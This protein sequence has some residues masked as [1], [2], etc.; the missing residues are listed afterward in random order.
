M[1]WPTRRFRCVQTSASAV[2]GL[3]RPGLEVIQSHSKVT[4]RPSSRRATKRATVAATS[5]G[6]DSVNLNAHEPAEMLIQIAGCAVVAVGCWLLAPWLGVLI[7]GAAL[8]AVG[9]ALEPKKVRD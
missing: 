1:R 2:P 7:A 8:L 3:F 9:I 4:S 5:G 6:D